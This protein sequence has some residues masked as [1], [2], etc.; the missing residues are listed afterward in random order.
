MDRVLI[1]LGLLALVVGALAGYRRRTGRRGLPPRIAPA[2]AGLQGSEGVGVVAFTGP[3]CLACR[4]WKR[5]L[6]EAGVR[7]HEIDVAARPDLARRYSVS[8]T[9][10]VLAVRLPDG[11]VATGYDGDPT[12]A[13]VARLAA[14]A[15]ID[16][17]LSV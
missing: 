1:V 8:A 10:V 14:L 5:E 9:P 7:F 3:Y 4:E 17:E 2:D 12:P 6:G 13:A 15:L 11:E 16:P